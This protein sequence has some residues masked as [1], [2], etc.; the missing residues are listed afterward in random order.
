MKSINN[1]TNKELTTLELRLVDAL[2]DR[3]WCLTHKINYINPEIEKARRIIYN[4]YLE[5]ERTK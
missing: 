3:Y 5:N 2:E 1:L 4:N